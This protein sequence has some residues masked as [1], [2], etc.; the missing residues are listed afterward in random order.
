MDKKPSLQESF[1]MALERVEGASKDGKCKAAKSSRRRALSVIVRLEK[2]EGTDAA[3]K[4]REKL[5]AVKMG[6]CRIVPRRK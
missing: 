2:V 4:A 5:D 3:K 6:L 1:Q